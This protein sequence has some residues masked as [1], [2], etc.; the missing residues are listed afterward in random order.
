MK[1]AREEKWTDFV[2]GPVKISRVADRREL[3]LGAWAT[4]DFG[5]VILQNDKVKFVVTRIFDLPSGDRVGGLLIDAGRIAEPMDFLGELAFSYSKAFDRLPYVPDSLKIETKSDSPGDA[6][7]VLQAHDRLYPDL[8]FSVRYHLGPGDDFMTVTTEIDNQTSLTLPD[9]TLTDQ[10]TLGGMGAFVGGFG[11]PEPSEMVTAESGWM[12]GQ[13]MKYSLGVVSPEENFFG[14]YKGNFALLEYKTGALAPGS[15]LQSQ[16]VVMLTD[17]HMSDISDFYFEKKSVPLG[18]I[19][20]KVIDV[21]TKEGV[22]NA[23]VRIRHYDTADRRAPALPLTRTFTRADGSF[24]VTVPAGGYF[25]S[26]RAFGRESAPNPFSLDVKANQSYVTELGVSPEARI[27]LEVQDAATRQPVPCKVTFINVAPTPPVEFGAPY[28]GPGAL[29]TYYSAT[30]KDTF[31]VHPGRYRAIVSHGLEYEIFETEIIPTVAQTTP[32]SCRLKR[33]INTKGYL[34]ADL[35]VATNNSYSCLVSPENRVLSAVAEG[36]E[37]LVSGDSNK[38]FDLSSAA[39]E[40]GLDPFV[41]TLIGKRIE[42][43]GNKVLGSFLIFPFTSAE[44]D[45]LADPESYLTIPTATGLFDRLRQVYPGALI[46]VRRPI[47]PTV[48]YFTLNGYDTAAKKAPETAGVSYDFDLMEVAEGKRVGIVRQSFDAYAAAFKKNPRIIPVGVSNA[49]SIWGEETG[50]PRTF[51]A[52]ST[53][54]PAKA[55][56]GELMSNLKKGNIMITNGPWIDFKIN[57]QPM[58][59]VVTD[60]DGTVDCE[61]KITAAP[62]VDVTYIDVMRD[63]EFI[64]RVFQ[65]SVDE[66]QRYPRPDQPERGKVSLQ[67]KK[68]SYF[69]IIVE[70]RKALAPVV[71]DFSA[72]EGHVFPV[73]ISGPI[74]VDADGDGVFSLPEK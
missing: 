55:D 19:G 31:A 33:V 20:G 60:T 47:F 43:Y 5:D 51:I 8:L 26:S 23:E 72:T 45:P 7:L 67:A 4:G 40:M 57:N 62:W 41:K 2:S 61:I 32:L 58:G 66:I 9:V 59:T 56:V 71:P 29:N 12:V 63:G 46:S 34:S 53:D 3:L 30:G 70:G 50:Y 15:K 48:G 24:E 49:Q 13:A 38:A 74:Y 54:D 68:D 39:S 69:N 36:V 21:T 42:Y 73:A 17:D 35:G 16:R 52:S 28:E 10:M 44:N 65:P 14:T 37:V 1:A 64:R 25:I 22:A 6:D 11:A 18:V 27:Q